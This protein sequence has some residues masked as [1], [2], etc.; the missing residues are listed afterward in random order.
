M[1]SSSDPN[2]YKIATFHLKNKIFAFYFLIIYIDHIFPY[3][4]YGDYPRYRRKIRGHSAQGIKKLLTPFFEII[5]S[6]KRRIGN[7]ALLIKNRKIAPNGHVIKVRK[8]SI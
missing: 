3:G 5:S 1:K 8:A 6:Y 4:R 7:G 2:R